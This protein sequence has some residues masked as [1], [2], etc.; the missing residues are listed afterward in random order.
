MRSSSFILVYKPQQP[1]GGLRVFKIHYKIRRD[2]Y[3][4]YIRLFLLNK[5][6]IYIHILTL[7]TSHQ[8]VNIKTST[9]FSFV[10]QSFPSCVFIIEELFG[11]MWCSLLVVTQVPLLP[12]IGPR[13]TCIRNVN[14]A[15]LS[16]GLPFRHTVTHT[17]IVPSVERVVS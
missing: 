14:K 8:L 5:Y 2:R 15:L 6:Y 9:P 3:W 1:L 11:L 12:H 17:L 7:Y 4:E 13:M 16:F 10:P